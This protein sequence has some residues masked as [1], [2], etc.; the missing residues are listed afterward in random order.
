MLVVD[1]EMIAAC[2]PLLPTRAA[3][4]LTLS[5]PLLV[6]LEDQAEKLPLSKPSANIRSGTAEVAVEVGVLVGLLPP[7]TSLLWK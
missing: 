5:L 3:P 7:S 6:V 2:I 4:G 1:P